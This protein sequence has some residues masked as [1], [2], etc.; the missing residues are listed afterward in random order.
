MST[1]NSPA[2]TPDFA[3]PAET[4]TGSDNTIVSASASSVL[5]DR[6]GISPALSWNVIRS[7][8]AVMAPVEAQS[9]EVSERSKIFCNV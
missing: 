2:E 8:Q 4:N 7:Q 6:T 1:S 9:M 3:A 5:T